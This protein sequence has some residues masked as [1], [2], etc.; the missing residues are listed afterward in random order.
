VIHSYEIAI[1][2]GAISIFL[3]QF[4]NSNFKAKDIEFDNIA[5]FLEIKI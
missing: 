2:Y 5:I 4:R 1:T 3:L